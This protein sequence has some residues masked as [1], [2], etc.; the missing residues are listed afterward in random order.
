MKVA[1]LTVAKALFHLVF[2]PGL[3]VSMALSTFSS[4]PRRPRIWPKMASFSKSLSR[5]PEPTSQKNIK[6][7]HLRANLKT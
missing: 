2:A 5:R 1:Q 7:P 6:V 3:F 4:A